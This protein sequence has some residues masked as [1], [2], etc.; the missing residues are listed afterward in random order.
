MLAMPV[1]KGAKSPT[2]RFAGADDTYTIE[3]LM[4]NGWALQ[5]GTSHFLGQNFA[6]AFDVYYQNASEG[7]ELVWATSW[8]VSTRL[9]GALVMTHSDDKGLVLPPRVAPVQV[10]IVPI[11]KPAGPD[12]ER[13]MARVAQLEAALKAASIRVKVDHRYEVRPGAKYF[14]WERKGLPVRIDIGARDLDK[15]TAVLAL[16]HSGQKVNAD[17]ASD[18]AFAAAMK[19]TLDT[20]HDELLAA[21]RDRLSARTFRVES[22]EAMKALISESEE[23][24]NKAGFYLVPWRCDAANEAAI[25]EDCKA[26]IRCYPFAENQVPPAEGVKCFYSQHQATHMALFARAF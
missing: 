13:L 8:G 22:Y 25:K 24:K 6:R 21:A 10:V 2:E 15:N 23:D 1:V 9:I 4:Q 26:T 11:T 18:G 12:H 16:R 20:M 3:A 5:S 14:E 17:I 19:T 7:R